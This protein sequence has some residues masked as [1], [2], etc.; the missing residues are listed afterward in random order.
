MFGKVRLSNICTF[1]DDTQRNMEENS[2]YFWIECIDKYRI[3][4]EI[5]E[6]KKF[7]LVEV[8][9]SRSRD[10]ALRQNETITLTIDGQV[11]ILDPNPPE[12]FRMTY[13]IGAD[14]HLNIPMEI[15]RDNDHIP[16]AS[17]T[18]V[19]ADTDRQLHCVNVPVRDL[20]EL[21]SGR[22]S[23]YSPFMSY[24]KSGIFR[25]G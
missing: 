9:N 20:A 25:M 7:G 21:P 16:Y 5:E 8:N 19:D 14:N 15:H 18:F 3:E 24:R 22:Y 12:C 6:K 2:F 10:I 23:V 4:Q 17:M 13:L 11:K 1:I